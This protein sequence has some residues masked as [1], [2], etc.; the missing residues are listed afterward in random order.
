MKKVLTFLIVV[1]VLLFGC[2]GLNPNKSDTRV[3]KF[4]P[5]GFKPLPFGAK[6]YQIEEQAPD[7]HKFGYLI[8]F[9]TVISKEPFCAIDIL[10]G[11]NKD[12]SVFVSVVRLKEKEEIFIVGL[13]VSYAKNAF[14]TDVYEDVRLIQTGKP[15]F[16]LTK[17]KEPSSLDALIKMK[18]VQY[19]PKTE[20]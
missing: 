1:C 15:S 6:S 16:V 19:G 17:V 7:A 5:V 9:T 3:V 13:I 2:A 10:E 11:I 12:M 18:A 8:M 14:K 4:G 20:I